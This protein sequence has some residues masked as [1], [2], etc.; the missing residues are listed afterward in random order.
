MASLAD[1]DQIVLL[2]KET[3]CEN[4]VLLKCTSSYPSTPI[5]SNVITIPHFREL[6]NCEVGLSDHTLGIGAAIAA[7]AHGATVIEKHF[8]LNRS[9]GGVDSD[10]SMEP[11]E[12]REF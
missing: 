8:T 9:D 7:I 6:F 1:I 4:F 12:M 11:N 5:N 3:G 10:F 2:L